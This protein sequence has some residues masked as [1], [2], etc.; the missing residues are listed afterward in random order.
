MCDTH[1]PAQD[2]I[3]ASLYELVSQYWPIKRKKSKSQ[4]LDDG[5]DVIEEVE[6][7]GAA[8]EGLAAENSSDPQGSPLPD[9]AEEAQVAEGQDKARPEDDLYALLEEVV[10]EPQAAEAEKEAQTPRAVGEPLEVPETGLAANS[11]QT[12]D[13]YLDVPKESLPD[14]IDLGAIRANLEEHLSLSDNQVGAEVEAKQEGA[15]GPSIAPPSLPPL[16]E[17]GVKSKER[18]AELKA[19]IAEA[20]RLVR[21]KAF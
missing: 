15:I 13:P 9:E 4:Q 1:G 20:R 2:S 8:E 19:Q 17:K 21:T 18:A 6:E 10:E 12:H 3:V 7:S 11:V 14:D 5:Y 16:Q